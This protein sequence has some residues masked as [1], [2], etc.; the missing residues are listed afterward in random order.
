MYPTLFKIGNFE[1]PS[2]GVMM[3]LAFF[4]G[5]WLANRRAARYGIGK[6]EVSDVLFWCLLFGILGARLG[7]IVQN[8]DYYSKNVNELLTLRF[9]GLTSFGGLILGAIAAIVYTKRKWIDLRSMMDL[10]GPAFMLGHVIGRIGC[11]LNGCCYG[12]ACPPDA[13][14]AM[15]IAGLPG[16]Y[17]PA[18]VYD[19]LMNLVGLGVVLW[20]ER[21]SKHRGQV[22]SLFLVLHGLARFIYEFWRA[23]VTAEVVRG[24]SLTEA[25]VVSLAMI[26]IGGGLFFYFGRKPQAEP[27][28]AA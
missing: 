26:A 15:R 9:Q 6:P 8:L 10:L 17:Q 16:T 1:V 21:R 14:F 19:S 5:Y 18:Q 4:A 24:L 13:P 25:Q 23:G 11:L 27:A 7:Y 22:F 28:V 3:V 20:F 2:F 12:N